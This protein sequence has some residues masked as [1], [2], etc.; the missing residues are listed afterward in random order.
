MARSIRCAGRASG[1][2]AAIARQHEGHGMAEPRERSGQR[3]RHFREAAGLCKRVRLGGHHQDA[4]RP[5]FRLRR[6][7]LRVSRRPG[8][9]CV[10]ARPASAP[11]ASISMTTACGPRASARVRQAPPA[12]ERPCEGRERVS[13]LETFALPPAWAKGVVPI[14]E[15]ADSVPSDRGRSCARPAR[16]ACLSE[17]GDDTGTVGRFFG[18]IKIEP[19]KTRWAGTGPSRELAVRAA[20]VAL[21]LLR[22][23]PPG[24]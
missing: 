16:Q 9:S 7:S 23:Q 22:T 11:P 10:W 8:R 18:D 17:I 5:G 2:D 14:P 13:R 20:R 3:G 6:R 24:R 4:Q 19:R 21:G 15:P 12:V 1:R